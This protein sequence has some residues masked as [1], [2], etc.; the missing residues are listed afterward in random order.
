LIVWEVVDDVDFPV[1]L[2]TN[3]LRTKPAFSDR[4]IQIQADSLGIHDDFIRAPVHQ[5]WYDSRIA[6]A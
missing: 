1:D 3:V 4:V 5:G 2:L 6:A